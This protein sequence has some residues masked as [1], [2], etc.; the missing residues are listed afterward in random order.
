[1]TCHYKMSHRKKYRMSSTNLMNPLMYL[2]A[3]FYFI[4]KLTIL[5]V[6][7]YLE[8]ITTSRL[9]CVWNITPTKSV[10]IYVDGKLYDTVT[11]ANTLTDP[12]ISLNFNPVKKI[13]TAIGSANFVGV[14]AIFLDKVLPKTD[15]LI[16]GSCTFVFIS[17]CFVSSRDRQ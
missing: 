10:S 8:R 13:R 1:M 4:L 9:A 17:R 11:E 16:T 2:V 14:S 12:F 5:R 3:H 6:K 15:K 7:I